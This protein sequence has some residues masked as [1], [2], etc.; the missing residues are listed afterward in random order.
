VLTEGRA[1]AISARSSPA[2]VLADAAAAAVFA[3]DPLPLVFHT[4]FALSWRIQQCTTPS[5]WE[6]RGKN[7]MSGIARKEFRTK[8]KEDW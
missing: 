1:T 3:R 6:K 7:E 5:S 2:L 4:P 8:R